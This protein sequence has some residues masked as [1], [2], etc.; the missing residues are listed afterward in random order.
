VLHAAGNC[1][2]FAAVSVRLAVLCSLGLSGLVGPMGCAGPTATAPPADAPAGVS[3]PGAAAPP[4]AA[5][6]AV[7][8]QPDIELRQPGAAIVHGNPVAF[9]GVAE[10]LS[11][12]ALD[13]ALPPRKTGDVLTIQ[14]ARGLPTIE[15][16][17]AAW[18]LRQADLHV[19][20]L[21]ASGTM[22][23]VELKARRD[24]PTAPGCHLALFLRPD[25]SLRVASPGGPVTI[26]GDDPNASLARSIAAE[27]ARCA[28]KYVA[29]GGESDTV[30]WGPIFDVMLAVDGSKSAGDTRYVLGQAMHASPAAAP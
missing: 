14:V 5:A 30:P 26:T 21:D 10:G 1:G 11:W 13:K 9:D 24:G 19:Q 23:A 25:G 6:L 18:S 4:S 8:A 22:H 7:A 16:L 28:I 27:Q 15:L 20:S 12:P 29:F 17:R 2:S 3:P